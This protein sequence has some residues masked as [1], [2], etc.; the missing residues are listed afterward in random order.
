VHHLSNPANQHVIKGLTVQQLVANHLLPTRLPSGAAS[1]GLSFAMDM[2]GGAGQQNPTSPS[3][4]C[5]A[6]QV[7]QGTP[8]WSGWDATGWVGYSCVTPPPPPPVYTP[9]SCVC[10]PNP[11]TG[12][13]SCANQGGYACTPGAPAA[14]PSAYA[15]PPP[16][17]APAPSGGSGGGGTSA[18]PPISN[19]PQATIPSS[20]VYTFECVPQGGE[21]PNLAPIFF[22]SSSSNPPNPCPAFNVFYGPLP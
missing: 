12:V 2:K 22:T 21:A 14:P 10:Q 5:G 9:P 16:P 3:P 17:P 20:P 11:F 15:P 6:G 1:F 13:V 18:T 8:K 19:P 4:T 7:M